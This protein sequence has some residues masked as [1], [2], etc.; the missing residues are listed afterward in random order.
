MFDKIII[1]KK[2]E[3]NQKHKT[4]TYAIEILDWDPSYF[5]SVNINKHL[6]E[7]PFWENLDIKIEGKLIHPEKLAEKNIKVNMI[8]SRQLVSVLEEPEKYKGFDANSVGT[9]TIRGKQRELFGSIPFDVMGSIISLI[10]S[11]KIKLIVLSGQ[12]LYHG[13]AEI[14]SIRFQKDFT[15]DD[16]L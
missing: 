10:Q 9:L 14:E 11:S 4:C 6:I 13:K 16:L 12:T 15:E 3:H 5:R 2:K 7:G 1:M 8:G